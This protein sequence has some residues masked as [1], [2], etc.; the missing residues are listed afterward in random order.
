MKKI[1]RLI[2]KFKFRLL[3]LP[4]D[5]HSDVPVKVIGYRKVAIYVFLVLFFACGAAFLLFRFTPMNRWVN[6]NAKLSNE[7]MAMISRLNRKADTLSA[8]LVKLRND[9][10]RLKYLLTTVDTNK[11]AGKDTVSAKFSVPVKKSGV[12]VP[13]KKTNQKQGYQRRGSRKKRP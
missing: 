7:D 1:K 3:L 9:N 10:D 4:I 11:P 5:N 2:Q 8:Q 6:V 13:P 12:G